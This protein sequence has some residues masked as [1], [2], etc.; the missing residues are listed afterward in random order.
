MRVKK[1]LEETLNLRDHA[2]QISK[3]NAMIKASHKLTR[4]SMFNMKA[5]V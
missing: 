1:L 4:L 2:A 3:T 5:I